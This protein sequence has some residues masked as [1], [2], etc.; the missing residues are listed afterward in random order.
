[1]ALP[2]ICSISF[3]LLKFLDRL[4]FLNLKVIA[5]KFEVCPPLI[6]EKYKIFLVDNNSC[7]HITWGEN[8][9]ICKIP[10]NLILT[11]PSQI[12]TQHVIRVWLFLVLWIWSDLSVIISRFW[13][14][15]GFEPHQEEHNW[16]FYKN[17]DLMA[18]S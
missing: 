17:K 14:Y 12:H 15:Q 10:P 11:I 7:F 13:P 5:W 4:L 16:N 2:N 8:V 9:A 18:A 6:A 3:F 1:M